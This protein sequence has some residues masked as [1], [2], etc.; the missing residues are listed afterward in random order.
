MN[1][2]KYFETITSTVFSIRYNRNTCFL[3]HIYAVYVFYM[4]HYVNKSDLA[5]AR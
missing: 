4:M 3:Q 2:L 5:G 1:L